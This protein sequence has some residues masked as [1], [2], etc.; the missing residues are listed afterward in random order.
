MTAIGTVSLAAVTVAAI[1]TTIVITRQDRRRADKRQQYA[2]A[3]L[4]Q[5]LQGERDAGPPIDPTYEE[6]GGSLKRLG[7]IVTNRG[8]YT[9]TDIGARLRLANSTVREFR[10]SERVTGTP[11]LD[12]RLTDGMT[13]LLEALSH[14]DRLA[15]WDV[16]LRFY[17]DPSPIESWYPIVRWT[18]RWGTRWE[19]RR[20]QVRPINEREPWK[21]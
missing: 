18:D 20:G 9:I 19:H 10:G 7:A 12:T 17:S 21:P 3:Y 16:G 11:G 4:V 15:P 8:S 14:G 5:V 1:I 6:S 13:G 2:E